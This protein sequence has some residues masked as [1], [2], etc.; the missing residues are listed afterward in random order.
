MKRLLLGSFSRNFTL[1]LLTWAACGNEIPDSA[2]D[3][4]QQSKIG[5]LQQHYETIPDAIPNL[6]SKAFN[7]S[8]R[9]QIEDGSPNANWQKSQAFMLSRR[10]ILQW[11]EPL[12]SYMNQGYRITHN[13]EYVQSGGDIVIVLDPQETRSHYE[14]FCFIFCDGPRLRLQQRDWTDYRVY[15]HEFG[16]AF[17]LSDVYI[18]GTG[19]C[20]EGQY[21]K[22][23][24]CSLGSD[25]SADDIRG[26]RYKYSQE[27]PAYSSEINFRDRYG[28]DG[29]NLA[30]YECADNRIVYG[31]QTRSGSK[32][33]S[34]Q[35]L[36][37]D[38]SGSKLEEGPMYG[39]AGGNPSRFV[40]PGNSYVHGIRIRSSAYVD[41]IEVICSDGSFS[42]RIGG[43]GGTVDV[44]Y[45]CT[46]SYPALKGVRVKSGRLIDSLGLT[47]STEGGQIFSH[48]NSSISDIK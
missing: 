17:G 35:V 33:D 10:A 23:I 26:I 36:C 44:G 15:L 39:G 30:A 3:V 40:C 19:V 8:I 46:D 14:G 34:L 28:G 9:V 1:S 48:S 32:L 18:E 12:R 24:M 4:E 29:G 13:I 38:R 11:L 7:S 6:L 5:Q 41:S 25:L 37:R 47:C 20:T 2:T 42:G 31:L 16:H 45:F 27:Y 43:G 22:S 21:T